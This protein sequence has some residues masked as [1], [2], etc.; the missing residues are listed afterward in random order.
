VREFVQAL[1]EL[2]AR[3]RIAPAAVLAGVLGLVTPASVPLAQPQHAASL[4][5]AEAPIEAG[6]LA[7]MHWYRH[8]LAW[9]AAPDTIEDYA[10]EAALDQALVQFTAHF[11]HPPKD[12]GLLLDE[13]LMDRVSAGAGHH[14]FAWVVPWPLLTGGPGASAARPSDGEMAETIRDLPKDPEAIRAFLEEQLKKQM[15]RA[16]SRMSDSQRRAALDQAYRVFK[17]NEHAIRAHAESHESSDASSDAAQ[18][19]PRDGAAGP[20]RSASVDVLAHELGHALFMSKIWGSTR[21]TNQYGGDAPD[22]LDEAAAI[23][24]ET[25]GMTRKRRAAFADYAGAQELHPLASFLRMP[26]PR[27]SGSATEGE[28]PQDATVPGR[29][30]PKIEQ[31]YLDAEEGRRRSLFYAQTRA[32]VDFLLERTG[33][34]RVFLEIAEHLEAGGDM[35]SWLAESA[36]ARAA[37]LG[38]DLP[39]L[40]RQWQDWIAAQAA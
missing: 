33:E 30:T 6:K 12:R 27:L 8:R 38:P 40:E 26:H 13:T 3:D 39:A 29:T 25:G 32:F 23:L 31:R 11:G 10:I 5:P 4:V 1:R 7:D 2:R 19:E 24:M 35:G 16:Y 9:V 15:P 20:G 18:A 17:Q 36:T 34:E 22:W 28:Q 21:T 37:G 14:R